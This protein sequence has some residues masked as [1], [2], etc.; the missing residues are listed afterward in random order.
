MLMAEAEQLAPSASGVSEPLPLPN[1]S[2]AAG[3][4]ISRKTSML[5]RTS[6]TAAKVVPGVAHIVISVQPNGTFTM[7]TTEMPHPSG[8]TVDHIFVPKSEADVLDGVRRTLPE[9]V[10]AASC[11]RAP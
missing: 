9:L 7:F 6:D 2:A 11:A 5:I 8:Y 10:A 3:E 1:D 4:R